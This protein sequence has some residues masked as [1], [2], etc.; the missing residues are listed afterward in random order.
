MDDEYVW[1]RFDDTVISKKY[2]GWEDI[3]MDSVEI[4]AWPSIFF[5]EKI[6]DLEN[7][8]HRPAL[9]RS[10]WIRE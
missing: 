4:M 3:V 7:F 1:M 5:Y 10:F 8:E 9:E 6:V 2:Y